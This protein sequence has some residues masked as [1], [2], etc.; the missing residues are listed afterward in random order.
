MSKTG[1]EIKTNGSFTDFKWDEEDDIKQMVND[2]YEVKEIHEIDENNEYYIVGSISGEVFNRFEFLTRNFTGSVYVY[3]IF[4]DV[5]KDL[6]LRYYHYG[7]TLED[8][9]LQ[10]ELDDDHYDNYYDYED[11]FIERDDVSSMVDYYREH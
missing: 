1:L 6:F 4:G 8:Y 11:G 3:N 2:T 7:E 5:D 9:L 10:D